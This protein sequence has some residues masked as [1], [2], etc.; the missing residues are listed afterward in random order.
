MRKNVKNNVF[1]LQ[2]LEGRT[3]MSAAPGTLTVK[4]ASGLLSVTGTTGNDQINISHVANSWTISNGSVWTSTKTYKNVTKVSI[5][6]GNGDDS[7]TLDS[8]VTCPATLAGGNGNDTITGSTGATSLDGGA[9]N[10]SLTA[11]GS[12]DVLTGDAGNDTLVGG[13]GAD[14]L[15][16]W[17]G[18]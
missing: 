5:N 13:A 1:D 4:F 2:Y 16:R 17:R 7:I 9:G 10:D 11:G 14:K 6:A 3:M 12:K 18:Q 8:S 15:M